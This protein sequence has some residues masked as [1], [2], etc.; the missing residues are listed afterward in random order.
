[1]TPVRGWWGS[2]RKIAPPL[3]DERIKEIRQENPDHFGG[4]D[5]LKPVLWLYFFLCGDR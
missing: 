2:R 4:G 1:M 5:W 3:S